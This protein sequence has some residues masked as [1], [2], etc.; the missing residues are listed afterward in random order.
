MWAGNTIRLRSDGEW[1]SS[2]RIAFRHSVL[3]SE[4]LASRFCENSCRM[5]IR[6][7]PI[8]TMACT[9]ISAWGQS[10]AELPQFE[11][12]SL[13]LVPPSKDMRPLHFDTTPTRVTYANIALKTLISVAFSTAESR[14]DGCPDWADS[15]L[16]DVAANVPPGTPKEQ[17]PPMLQ[18][19]LA[20]RLQLVVSHEA[21]VKSVYELVVAKNGP[22]LKPAEPG[23]TGPN[24]VIRGNVKGAS[25]P[26]EMLAEVLIHQVGKP[27]VDK[28]NLKGTYEIDLKWSAD[29]DSAVASDAPSGPSIYTA[30][31]EQLGLKLESRK[32]CAT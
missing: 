15:T 6:I 28:T 7:I 25:I 17:I 12:A 19:L 5:G 29:Y 22:K 9:L 3:C 1:Y 30:L 23:T 32:G 21:R 24:Y 27:V 14:I 13:R 11:V 20:E 26:M 31:E 10:P 16:Y 8:A 4:A 18:R 2:E